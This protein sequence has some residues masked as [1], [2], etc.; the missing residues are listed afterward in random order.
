MVYISNATLEVESVVIEYL[1]QFGKP[2]CTALTQIKTCP[3]TGHALTRD[4]FLE[5]ATKSEKIVPKYQFFH[6]PIIGTIKIKFSSKFV[7]WDYQ[8]KALEGHS[9]SSWFKF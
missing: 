7:C 8:C 6:V 3:T 5:I 9:H 1:K 2:L 4:F